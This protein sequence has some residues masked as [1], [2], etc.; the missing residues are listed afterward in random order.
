MEKPSV[1][2]VEDE[3][4][5]L[6]DIGQSFADAGWRVLQATSGEHA[7]KVLQEKGR[8]VDALFTDITLPGAL[9]GW[10]VADLARNERSDFPVVYASGKHSDPNRQLPGT[11]FFDKPYSP[12]AV[13]EACRQAVEAA[14]E[15]R[16]GSP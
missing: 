16:T 9:S 12:A 7:V 3:V 6:M 10:D 2:I 14:S 5:I 4:F 8:G 11:A 15:P 13:I 1:L